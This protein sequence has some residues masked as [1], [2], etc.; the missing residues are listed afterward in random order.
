M[1]CGGP[2]NL[3]CSG[4]YVPLTV[5]WSRFSKVTDGVYN[6]MA[7]IENSNLSAGAD[8][9]NYIFRLYD[10]KGAILRERT[11]TTFV[12]ASKIVAVFEPELLT[13]N[14]APARVDFSFT[15]DAVWTKQESQETGLQVS[16]SAI[17]RE[18]SAPRLSA[19]L[20]NKTINEIKNIEAIAIIYNSEGNT[21]AFSRTIVDAVAG[22]ASQTINFNWPK[23]F[24]D[25]YARSQIILK[26]L[27]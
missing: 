2:C 24:S 27:K 4:G 17:S 9:L 7:Y 19:V 21:V 10:E 12:P 1:D 18:D 13:G 23:P 11:G 6:V 16:Q 26:I 8:N 5:V 15:S 25:T 3:L 20:T 14:E 22:A